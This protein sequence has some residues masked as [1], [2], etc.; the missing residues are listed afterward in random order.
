M[1]VQQ[2]TRTLFPI[3][4]KPHNALRSRSHAYYLWHLNPLTILVHWIILLIVGALLFSLVFFQ[5]SPRTRA[6]NLIIQPDNTNGQDT[7]AE[8]LTG[9]VHGSET[10]MVSEA[11]GGAGLHFSFITFPL[12]DIPSGATISSAT[13]SLYLT[14]ND[15]NNF[16]QLEIT[17]VTTSW[18]ESTL[19]WFNQPSVDPSSSYRSYSTASPLS[20]W[21]DLPLTTLVQDWHNG[22]IANDGIRIGF[23]NPGSPETETFA[24]SEASASLRPKLSVNYTG[25]IAPTPTPTPTPSSGANTGGA[26][27]GG[28]KSGGTKS[29]TQATPTPDTPP[30]TSEAVPSA[31]P[32]T[33]SKPFIPL[34]KTAGTQSHSVSQSLLA[35]WRENG[36]PLLK[37][38]LG[39]VAIVTVADTVLQSGI[40]VWEILKELPALLYALWL[41]LLI[42]LGLR[43]KQMPWGR[44]VNSVT[45]EPIPLVSISLHNQDN[46][47]RVEARAMTDINGRFGFYA[48]P[49]HYSLWA[50]KPGYVFPSKL[51]VNTYRG[52]SFEIGEQGMIILDLFCDPIT[53]F[54]GWRTGMTQLAYWVA[55]LRVPLLVV[56]SIVSIIFFIHFASVINGIILFLYAGAWGRE[57]YQRRFNRHTLSVVGPTGQ[58]VPFATIRVVNRHTKTTILTRTTDARGEIYIL[59]PRG[60]Y[61]FAITNPTTQQVTEH[62]ITLSQGLF[63]RHKKV[64][65][66]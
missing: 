66:N 1:R 58:P 54:S 12:S 59:V 4:R 44:A 18:D 56:G 34:L 38:I 6:S 29:G 3:F 49:G 62:E 60:D 8:Y 30:A 11:S 53:T 55:T 2:S 17:R 43:K 48:K 36:S 25:G 61:I 35:D 9:T 64:S 22:I 28:T 63:V 26:T 52:G 33:Q 16:Q 23:A 31:T 40:F 32:T 50:Q 65:I 45:N 13:L 15:P 39:S 5:F 51:L 10:T 37:S 41:N 47:N 46:Y 27:G 21:L 42:L 57:L 24:T 19:Q 20:G 14:Y 7:W